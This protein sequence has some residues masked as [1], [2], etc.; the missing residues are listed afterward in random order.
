LRGSDVLLPDLLKQ[1]QQFIADKAYDAAKRVLELLEAS[2]VEAARPRQIEKSSG[3]MT[4]RYT[5]GVI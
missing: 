3:R 4:K 5:S 2:Q 1:A